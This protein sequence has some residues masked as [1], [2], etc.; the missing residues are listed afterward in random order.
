MAR[1]HDRLAAALDP[2]ILSGDESL[3]GAAAW[4][5]SFTQGEGNVLNYSLIRYAYVVNRPFLDVGIL[6]EMGLLYTQGAYCEVWIVIRCA[7]RC[8]GGL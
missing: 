7:S 2:F 5:S 3:L 4:G 6:P 1:L 8:S